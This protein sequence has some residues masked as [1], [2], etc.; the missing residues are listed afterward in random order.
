MSN[1]AIF[2]D[3]L[4]EALSDVVYTI[5]GPKAVAA[6]LWPAKFDAN[7]E[8]TARYVSQC[9]EPNRREKFALD[10]IEWLFAAGRG[11]NAHTAMRYIAHKCNY[12]EP[13]PIVPE[14]ERDK[15][16]R[17]FVEAVEAQR[18]IIARMESLS[19]NVT[20]MRSRD[21]KVAGQS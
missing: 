1:N 13:E 14:S 15:L 21:R 11:A 19:T 17:E 20:Q 10:E 7:P 18:D 9:L 5:G 6:E 3:T 8:S 12:A 2:S 4:A 16:Q